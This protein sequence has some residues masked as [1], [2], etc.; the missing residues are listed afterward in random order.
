MVQFC[1][2]EEKSL[3][4]VN[5]VAKFLDE[6]KPKIRTVSNFIDPKVIQFYLICQMLAKFSVSEFK[7]RKRNFL[8]CV[9]LLLKAGARN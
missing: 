8:S 6:K 9:H 7:K 3:R 5:T 2:G 1:Y 4:H